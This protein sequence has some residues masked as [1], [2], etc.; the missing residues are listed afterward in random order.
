M[1]V[2]RSA[3][4][5]HLVG[6]FASI[7][8]MAEVVHTFAGLFPVTLQTAAVIALAAPIAPWLMALVGSESAAPISAWVWP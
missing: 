6:S 4:R 7:A 2:L 8:V 5:G 1:T 3:V